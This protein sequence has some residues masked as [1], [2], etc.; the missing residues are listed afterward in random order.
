MLYSRCEFFT[1]VTGLIFLLGILLKDVVY[2]P[3]MSKNLILISALDICGY[4]FEF[5]NGKVVVCF[6]YVS[7]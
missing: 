7:Q 6:N 1:G 3:S 4:T 2:V 5:G